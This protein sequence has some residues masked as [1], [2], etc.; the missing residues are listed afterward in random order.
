MFESDQ[1]QG[2]QG[3]FHRERGADFRRQYFREGGEVDDYE[4]DGPDRQDEDRSAQAIGRHCGGKL[5][6]S[7]EA[8][9]ASSDEGIFGVELANVLEPALQ[10]AVKV[11]RRRCF[12]HDHFSSNFVNKRTFGKKTGFNTTTEEF[13]PRHEL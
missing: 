8:G 7:S 3:S 4:D 9:D 6:E 11:F 10:S 2:R 13:I 12:V 5:R 1:E